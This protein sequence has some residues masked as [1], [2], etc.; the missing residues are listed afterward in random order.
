MAEDE[1][2]VNEEEGE[3]SV[4]GGEEMQVNEKEAEEL[5]PTEKAENSDDNEVGEK[6]EATVEN[7][8]REDSEDKSARGDFEPIKEQ[9]ISQY[10]WDTFLKYLNKG[11]QK[12]YNW[13]M[14]SVDHAIS[15]HERGPAKPSSSP[16]EKADHT[17][18][19]G[20]KLYDMREAASQNLA[21]SIT[22]DYLSATPILKD[23]NNRAAF[24]NL[25]V[26]AQ[27]IAFDSAVSEFLSDKMSKDK[28][29]NF[30][31]M[32]TKKL[33]DVLKV[34]VAEKHK[35]LM[36]GALATAFYSETI[37]GASLDEALKACD[38]YLDIRENESNS[39]K[40]LINQDLDKGNFIANG[41]NPS[42]DIAVKLN[43]YNRSFD[44]EAGVVSLSLQEAVA[45]VNTSTL[46]PE[47]KVSLQ[48]FQKSVNMF[49]A[50][51]NGA[52]LDLQRQAKAVEEAYKANKNSPL[53]AKIAAMKKANGLNPITVKMTQKYSNNTIL[54]AAANKVGGRK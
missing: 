42:K 21:S 40:E 33:S 22:D 25:L 37:E 53:R 39:I 6:K 10:L 19:R 36:T 7:E 8:P 27:G 14:D 52:V 1:M 41:K 9:D 51:E 48:E 30:A 32:D 44:N 46:S 28:D 20:K 43:A 35:K 49:Q 5:K 47:E 50:V 31:E 38:E 15:K 2:K 26:R 17:V 34:R 24:K 13:T 12:V 4:G 11:L 18:K 29:F 45:L 16:K 23:D 3:I 54:R